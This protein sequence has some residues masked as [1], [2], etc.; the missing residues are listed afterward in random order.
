MKS[1][2]F[3]PLFFFP[4]IS[5]A[6][7]TP[8]KLLYPIVVG[9]KWGYIDA[10]GKTVIKPKFLSA[11]DFF[12]GLAPVRQGGYYG[13]IDTNGKFRIPAIYD[14]ARTF[15]SGLAEVWIKGKKSYINR[16]GEQ[17]FAAYYVKTDGFRQD[18]NFAIV[19]T[20]SGK[21]GL[22]RRDGK[23]ILDTIYY[24]IKDLREGMYLVSR[25]LKTQ[26]TFSFYD[27]L[28][29][30]I[31]VYK[32]YIYTALADTNGIVREGIERFNLYNQAYSGGYVLVNLDWNHNSRAIIDRKGNMVYWFLQEAILW[33]F[34]SNFVDFTNGLT[35]VEYFG[36]TINQRTEKGALEESIKRGWLTVKG[37]LV[38]PD[39]MVNQ[40]TAFRNGTALGRI[41]EQ[42]FL[43]DRKGQRL[44]DTFYDGT[45]QM[46]ERWIY[47]NQEGAWVVVDTLGRAVKKFPG[48]WGHSLRFQL[49]GRYLFV[50]HSGTC[51]I[52][53][54]LRQTCI[55]REIF[56]ETDTQNGFRQGILKVVTYKNELAYMDTLGF[57][58]WKENL[59]YP[60]ENN[61]KLN[62]DHRW[63]NGFFPKP[64]HSNH[65]LRVGY[66]TYQRLP[67]MVESEDSSHGVLH[68][69]IHT[70]IKAANKEKYAN[71]PMYLTNQTPDTLV[72]EN[73]GLNGITLHIEALDAEH[74]WRYIQGNNPGPYCMSG[75][76]DLLLRPGEQW[77]FT[78]PV[79]DGAIPTKLRVKGYGRSLSNGKIWRTVS[80]EIPVRINPGQFWRYADMQRINPKENPFLSNH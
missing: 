50:H 5:Q 61:E 58:I 68:L 30:S 65:L 70:Q 19:T 33:R 9:Q 28:A 79:F 69:Q 48:R 37:E 32:S 71:F 22:L 21:L 11:G 8:E 46:M 7:H 24:S 20:G 15:R 80:N 43:F 63:P 76:T 60:A 75:R 26:Q 6:Q 57:I 55:T 56:K 16:K 2:I 38:F 54:T 64:N 10:L 47:A 59:T 39:T 72:F 35:P 29:D 3:L 17:P 49:V 4:S 40:V 73:L 74:Q 66:G 27:P 31:C 25:N 53:D 44:S 67:Y 14:Y 41:G 36:M 34:P 45:S 12:E 13:F 52:W 78:V 42:W 1:L 62:I 77:T 51:H 23:L 18:E